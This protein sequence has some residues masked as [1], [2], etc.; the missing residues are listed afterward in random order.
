[1]RSRQFERPGLNVKDHCV[2][3]ERETCWL[4]PLPIVAFM[5]KTLRPLRLLSV[6]TPSPCMSTEMLTRSLSINVDL[7][8]LPRGEAT[9]TAGTHTHERVPESGAVKQG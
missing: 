9:G 2:P 3:A 5:M 7:R 1:M 8:I 4:S 6:V